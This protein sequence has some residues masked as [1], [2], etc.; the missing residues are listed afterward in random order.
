MVHA[1]GVGSLSTASVSSP[2]V[3]GPSSLMPGVMVNTGPPG[4]KPITLRASSSV[5]KCPDGTEAMVT[6]TVPPPLTSALSCSG[7]KRPWRRRGD[8]SARGTGKSR[9]SRLC[10]CRYFP[11]QTARA[12][13]II[14]I[15]PRSGTAILAGFTPAVPR[16]SRAPKLC[17]ADPRDVARDRCRDHLL[18]VRVDLPPAR[19]GAVDGVAP[20]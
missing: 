5:R 16:R 4:G 13:R 15:S 19:E 18:A 9:P 17:L 1:H 3:R 11:R 2:V 20:I 6:L 8:P 7:T 10:P 12:L 14:A